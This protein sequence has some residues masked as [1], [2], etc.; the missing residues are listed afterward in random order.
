[1]L[2]RRDALRGG[3]ASLAAIAVTGAVAA[4]VPVLTGS[5]ARLEDLYRAWRKAEDA[6]SKACEIEFDAEIFFQGIEIKGPDGKVHKALSYRHG[7]VT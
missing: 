4:A 7:R 3:T 6:F 2:S 1:M 5:D